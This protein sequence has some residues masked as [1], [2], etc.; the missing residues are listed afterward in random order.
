MNDQIIQIDSTTTLNFP[1]AYPWVE[2][3][4]YNPEKV[5]T[6]TY[7]NLLILGL[8]LISIFFVVRKFV[9]PLIKRRKVRDSF[10]LI[11]PIVEAVI[12]IIFGIISI[13]YLVIPYP[14]FGLIFFG[15]FVAATWEFLK[16][17][18]AGLLFR[19]SANSFR[20]GQRIKIDKQSGMVKQLR[21]LAME[22]EVENGEVLLMPYGQMA[23]S[24]F[25]RESQSEKIMSYAFELQ[26]P[27]KMD[28]PDIK[29]HL[30]SKILN[31]PWSIGAR[32]PFLEKI[33][34]KAAGTYRIVLYA[35]ND[36]Y[37]P[38][39]EEKLRQEL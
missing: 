9:I 28:D 10:R 15:I 35:L 5:S 31:L 32:D 1:E 29:D 2:S 18:F 16:D 21:R 20:P 17:Y 36:K 23:N 11:I 4:L 12:A 33:D 3:L 24:S 34:T 8:V 25:I 19:F 13:F 38:L 37:F 39:M 26:I 27:E 6:L 7:I 14:L 30:R 22:I